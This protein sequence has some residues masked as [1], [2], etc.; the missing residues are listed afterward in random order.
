MELS[1]HENDQATSGEKGNSRPKCTTLHFHVV[2]LAPNAVDAFS[3]KAY[4]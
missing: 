2:S 3:D 1:I 4:S